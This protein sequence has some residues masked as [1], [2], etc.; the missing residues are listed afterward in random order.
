MT[1]SL[2]LVILAPVTTAVT[3]ATFAI[4][5]RYISV[6]EAAEFLTVSRPTLDNWRHA[7]YGPPYYR[8]GGRIA[9]KIKDLRQWAEAR[10]VV[11]GQ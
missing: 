11:P 6:A 8:I 10:L 3:T 7:K 1:A 4:E 5:D 9:Y 2:G